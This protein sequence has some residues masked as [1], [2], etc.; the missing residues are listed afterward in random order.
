MNRAI[1]ALFLTG[2]WNVIDF[3]SLGE[4]AEAKPP[5]RRPLQE[6][7]HGVFDQGQ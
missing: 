4:A 6:A 2:F 1:A 7:D 5:K 3:V